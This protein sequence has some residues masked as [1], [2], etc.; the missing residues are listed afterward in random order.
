MRILT[1]LGVATATALLTAAATVAQ[2]QTTTPSTTGTTATEDQART[3]TTTATSGSSTT[4]TTGAMD[5][6]TTGTTS[7]S[8]NT[9]ATTTGRDTGTTSG[10]A[11]LQGQDAEFLRKAMEGGREEVQKAQDAM[12]NAQ[13]A[14]TRNAAAMMLK[15]HQRANEQL[16]RLA[17]RKGWSVPAAPSMQADQ[18]RDQSRS[19]TMGGDFD[20]RYIADEI[21]HHRE[22]IALYRAQA[23]GGSDPE[24][25]QFARESLPK[26]EHHL[27]MLESARTGK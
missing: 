22:T 19:A 10:A 8:T 26:L 14:D 16:E 27:E 18:A 23:S 12:Q 3:G 4:D 1:T 9:R 21:R 2:P 20:D 5:A 11:S 24:L 17:Q 15:D 13:R 25:T 6:T 7:S